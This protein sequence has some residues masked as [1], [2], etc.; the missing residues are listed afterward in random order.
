MG[1]AVT[2]VGR[3]VVGR[4]GWGAVLNLLIAMMGKTFQDSH[5]DTHCTWIFPFA[6]Q[7]G[8]SAFCRAS[9]RALRGHGVGWGGG[10]MAWSQRSESRR[11]IA[12]TSLSSNT[13]TRTQGICT[14]YHSGL[15]GLTL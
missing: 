14:D 5:E 4:M 3:N 6:K 12:G 13:L 1:S 10:Q 15:C 9:K 8:K 11:R 7:V 2:S